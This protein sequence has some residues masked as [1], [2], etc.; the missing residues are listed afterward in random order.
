[1]IFTSKTDL[2]FVYDLFSNNVYYIVLSG[3]QNEKT[4][5]QQLVYHT[6]TIFG[7]K[8]RLLCFL[9]NVYHKIHIAFKKEYPH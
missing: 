9:K 3:I 5:I 2:V 8:M 6:N 4:G 7:I 1:M